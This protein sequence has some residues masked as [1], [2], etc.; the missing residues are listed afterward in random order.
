MSL[1]GKEITKETNEKVEKPI[2]TDW[3]VKEREA[4]LARIQENLSTFKLVALP[5][6]LS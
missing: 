6:I 5:E 1:E 3:G 2:L 4:D